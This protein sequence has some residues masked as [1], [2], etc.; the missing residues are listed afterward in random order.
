[1]ESAQTYKIG[2]S[3]VL[4]GSYTDISLAGIPNIAEKSQIVLTVKR[5]GG[6]TVTFKI[7]EQF[8]SLTGFIPKTEDNGTALVLLE[9]TCTEANFSYAFQSICETMQLSVKGAGT[10]DIYLTIGDA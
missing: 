6:S 10:V 8:S 2:A 7:A 5:T 3:V 4:S 9:R 1:M